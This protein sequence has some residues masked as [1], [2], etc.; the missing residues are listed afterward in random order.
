MGINLYRD[1]L[2]N[3]PTV[4][5]VCSHIRRFLEL[6]GDDKHVSLGSDFDGMTG[7]PDGISGV[8][9]YEV[10]ADRLIQLG[11]SHETIMNIFWNNALGVIEKCS[12]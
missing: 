10:L 11:I 7:L 6:A 5:T 2:G 8:Q 3:N 12:M 9:D 1:F 4:D